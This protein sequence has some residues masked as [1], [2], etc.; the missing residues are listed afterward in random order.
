MD[1]WM[2]VTCLVW[3]CRWAECGLAPFTREPCGNE[4]TTE[5][6]CVRQYK[7]CWESN[8]IPRCY[9]RSQYK[10]TLSTAPCAARKHH[11]TLW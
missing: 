7:C 5:R 9:H 1:A 4:T 3:L 8:G 11:M 2:D 10:Q 6:C